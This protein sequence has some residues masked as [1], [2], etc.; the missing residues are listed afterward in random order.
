MNQGYPKAG[1]IWPKTN[2]RK[3]FIIKVSRLWE[4]RKVGIDSYL[5]LNQ[6]NT[7]NTEPQSS[8]VVWFTFSNIR[9]CCVE[10]YR[11]WITLLKREILEILNFNIDVHVLWYN[12]FK[13][14]CIEFGVFNLV[15]VAFFLI[16]ENVNQGQT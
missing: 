8:A 3:S 11:T 5:P 4:L 15:L 14:Y 7:V 2:L 16:L 9:W 12:T 13:I 6:T 1:H 10:F